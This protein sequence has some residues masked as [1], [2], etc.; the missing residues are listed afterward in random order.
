MHKNATK[1]NETIGKWCKNK[2]GASK[3][4]DTFETYHCHGEYCHHNICPGCYV[5]GNG[6]TYS[7][8]VAMSTR[9][10][11]YFSLAYWCWYFCRWWLTTLIDAYVHIALV[12]WLK[13]KLQKNLCC[14][15]KGLWFGFSSAALKNTRLCHKRK[16]SL[17]ISKICS[18]FWT[19]FYDHSY[20]SS[21][22]Y[23]FW[24]K[25]NAGYFVL[26]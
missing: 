12:L 23:S 22:Y 6:D 15:F 25:I 7:H 13:L 16:K 1:C 18:F 17:R 2:H 14:Y 26:T 8:L 9:L 11:S 24:S 10:Y 19:L 21:M 4:I 3:I 5:I 20:I